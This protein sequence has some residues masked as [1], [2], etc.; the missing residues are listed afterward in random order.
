MI[1]VVESR[2]DIAAVEFEKRL[3][4]WRR[5]VLYLGHGTGTACPGWAA[6]YIKTRDALDAPAGPASARN[7]IS[8]EEL[9][10]WM[11]EAA[12]SA[13]S[14]E[15]DKTVLKLWY[16]SRAKPETIRCSMRLRRMRVGDLLERAKNNLQK[17]LDKRK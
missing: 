2:V 17:E 12:W 16:V 15:D 5:T 7:L 11:I 14:N 4:N 1:E 9:D 8:V 13:L 10:G 6:M 3:D